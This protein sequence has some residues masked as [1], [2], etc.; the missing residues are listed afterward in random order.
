MIA[1]SFDGCGDEGLICPVFEYNFTFDL[2]SEHAS[3]RLHFPLTM[4]IKSRLESTLRYLSF[5]F[6][7]SEEDIFKTRA[8]FFSLSQNWSVSWSVFDFFVISYFVRILTSER[9]PH[10]TFKDGAARKRLLRR[11]VFQRFFAQSTKGRYRPHIEGNSNRR[12][13]TRTR[14]SRRRRENEKESAKGKSER[15]KESGNTQKFKAVRGWFCS[16]REWRFY[17]TNKLKRSDRSRKEKRGRK[18]R[19]KWPTETEIWFE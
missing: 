18:C 5:F 9:F 7:L 8:L 6:E 12:S 17:A 14:L 3:Q 1:T 15:K 2:Y 10:T 19:C 4:P 11:K 16:R 13:I